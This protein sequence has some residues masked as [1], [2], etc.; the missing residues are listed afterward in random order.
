MN[1]KGRLPQSFLKDHPNDP[2]RAEVETFIAKLQMHE[3]GS[4]GTRETKLPDDRIL[5]ASLPDLAP[6]AWGPPDVDEAK[7][8][9]TASLVCPYDQIIAM[10]GKRVQQLVEDVSQFAATEDLL[11]EQLDRYGNPTTRVNRQF[12]Y[13]AMISENPPG[14][15]IVD[16]NRMARSSLSDIPDGIITRG[17]MSLALIFHP[18]ARMIFKLLAKASVSGRGRQHG[19]SPSAN[20]TTGPAALGSSQRAINHTV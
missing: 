4:A 8:A 16:E 11:H 7:P 5:G 15:F 19:S 17:F 13:L 20:A 2:N 9:V 10:S 3:Q 6:S 14:H 18:D 1:A 12:D